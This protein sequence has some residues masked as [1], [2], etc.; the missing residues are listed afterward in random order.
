M[1]ITKNQIKIEKENKKENE[2][3]IR[4]KN[5]NSVNNSL[6]NVEEIYLRIMFFT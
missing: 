6:T 3:K 4:N 2:N 1:H 5:E